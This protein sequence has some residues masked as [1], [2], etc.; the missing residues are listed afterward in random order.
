MSSLET[1]GIPFKNLAF[2]SNFVY[3]GDAAVEVAQFI[4]REGGNARSRG[5][6]ALEALWVDFTVI[7]PEAIP[8]DIPNRQLNPRISALEIAS[9]LAG[10]PIDSHQRHT[11]KALA[12]YQDYGVQRG[13]YGVRVRNQ[14]RDFV[15][16][17][18]DDKGSRQAV[19]AV[20][21][22]RDLIDESDDVPCTLH[23]QGMIRDD[24]FFMRTTMRSNDVLLGLPYDL[25][26]F[27]ALQ[28]TLAQVFDIPCGFYRHSVGSM[29]CYLADI[30]KVNNM[31]VPTDEPEGDN[32]WAIPDMDDPRDRMAYVQKF[33]QDALFGQPMNPQTEFEM[34]LLESI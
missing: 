30:D 18:M 5:M 34:W 17:L 31:V 22:D 23:I 16:K 27:C 19:L 24:M 9:F 29:H 2:P 8:F 6:A 10:H 1:S 25:H 4:A 33:C 3:P 11:M 20:W 15:S 28:A 12:A 21:Q 13:N 14:L 7:N 26:V 32:L